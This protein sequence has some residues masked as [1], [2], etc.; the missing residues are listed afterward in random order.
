MYRCNNCRSEFEEPE[1]RNVIAEEHLGISN[2]FPNITRMD[3]F[4]CPSCGD[5]D[6]EELE[7]CEICEEW[8]K[9]EDLTDTEGMVG[10]GC[11]YACPQCLEDCEIY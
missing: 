5:D 8:F 6:L 1:R 4:V 11:G 10:G 3:L 7:Q 2:M 9:N